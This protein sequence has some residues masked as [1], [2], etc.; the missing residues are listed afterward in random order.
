MRRITTGIAL[1]SIVASC[2]GSG[3]EGTTSSGV[4]TTTSLLTSSTTDST[5]TVPET[6]TTEATTTTTELPGNWA[7]EP[8]VTSAFG[9]LGWWDGANW[10]QVDDLTSL[11]VSGGEDY[12]VV[13][14][15][16]DA[17]ITGG[18]EEILCEPVLNPGVQ[19]SNTSVLGGP[20]PD[21]IGLAVSA[22]W[23]LTPH[24]VQVETDDGTFSDF[25]R[26]LL[27][28]RG[29]T[30]ENP[31]IKQVVRFDLDG[32]GVNEVVAVAEEVTGD[33][34]I[35]A[36]EGNYS[37][38]FMR[39]VVDGEVQTTILG[40]SIVTHLG[41]GEIPAIL[42]H[43]VAAVADL[44]GDGKMEIVVDEVYYE[45]EGW[46]VWEYVNDDLGPV[47]QIGSACGV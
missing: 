9:A 29:L 4:D 21:P 40:E 26:P 41:E 5:T 35:Y 22:P 32:D 45:G 13:L 2:G 3:G 33:G 16:V 19:L 15:G 43:A 30:V 18:P 34:G 7:E 27:A 14:Q 42:T 25:A 17:I 31:I 11:P 8:L 39:R 23:E 6:T 24:F 44:S 46:S 20:F 10:V 12:Q 47:R 28:D 1:L 36:E 37:L 38:V